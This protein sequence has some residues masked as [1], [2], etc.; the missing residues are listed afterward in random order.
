MCLYL[1]Q[2]VYICL[3]SRYDYVCMYITSLQQ[4]TWYQEEYMFVTRRDNVGHSLALVTFTDKGITSSSKDQPWTFKL[5]PLFEWTKLNSQ[6]CL[7]LVVD[8]N[9]FLILGLSWVMASLRPDSAHVAPPVTA[10]QELRVIFQ[11]KKT[12]LICYSQL[13]PYL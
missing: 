9:I 3:W 6:L 7:G 2:Y 13:W 4:R 5:P 12:A 8:V 11:A 1:L 10:E